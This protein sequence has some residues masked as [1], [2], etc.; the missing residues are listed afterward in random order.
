MQVL[1]EKPD[2]AAISGVTA[3]KPLPRIPDW[4][5]QVTARIVAQGFD[6]IG[7]VLEQLIENRKSA[8]TVA[9]VAG[10]LSVSERLVY[11]LV[12]K[13]EIPHFKVA[14]AVRFDPQALHDWLARKVEDG[15]VRIPPTY[16]VRRGT[17]KDEG[18]H[19]GGIYPRDNTAWW[20]SLLLPEDG[21]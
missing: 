2:F 1:H 3:T 12:A 20:R 7:G 16:T 17:H 15:R 19:E 9:E 6:T 11:D 21:K 4:N 18:S 5:A 10:F 8:L 14:S 13:G